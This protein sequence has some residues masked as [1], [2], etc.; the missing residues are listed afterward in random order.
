MRTGGLETLIYT[1]CDSE[2]LKVGEQQ[3]LGRIYG[4][5]KYNSAIL[6]Q[7]TIVH[8]HYQ[9]YVAYNNYIFHTPVCIRT[10]IA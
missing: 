9:P 2:L 4:T 3:H 10:H 8:L 7:R 6:V 1:T 5:G